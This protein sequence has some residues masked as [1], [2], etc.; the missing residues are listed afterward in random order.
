MEWQHVYYGALGI[1]GFFIA[2]F[3]YETL[4]DMIKQ[5]RRGNRRRRGGGDD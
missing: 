2:V 5:W 3:L 1:V 4:V